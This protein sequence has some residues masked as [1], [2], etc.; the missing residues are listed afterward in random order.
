MADIAYQAQ[1]GFPFS[2]T[3][4]PQNGTPFGATQAQAEEAT[5]PESMIETAKFTPISGTN[6]GKEQAVGGRYP[7][8]TYK[9]KCTYKASEHAAA[10]AC[11]DARAMGRLTVT[12][13]DGVEVYGSGNADTVNVG[14]QY[15]AQVT[16]VQPGPLTAT[17]LRTAEITVTTP[18]PPVF[19]PS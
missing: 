7:V 13:S 1:F 8:Q 19:T 4:T 10:L 17:G 18:T 16:G 15:L 12:Y 5:P 6:A 11:L 9:I 3:F 2:F 14:S